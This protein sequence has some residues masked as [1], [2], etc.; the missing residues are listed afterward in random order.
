MKERVKEIPARAVEFWN[1]YTSKQK[2]IIIAVICVVLLLIAL[3]A[4][5]VSRPT[6]TKFNEFSKL[7]DASAMVDALDEQG[8]ANK[9]SKDGLTIY[10]HDDQMTE[11]FYT[12]SDNNLVD[13]GYTWDKAFD[14]SMSTTE[15]EKSQKRVL[16]LQSQL[17]NSMLSYSF[18]DDADVFIDVPESSYSILDEANDTSVTARITVSEKNKE[19]LTTETAQSLAAW[20]AGA[21]GTDVEHVV[22]NDSDGNSVYNGT[23]SDGLGGV[24]TGGVTEYCDKLRNN[25]AQN[26]IKILVKCGYDDVEVGTQ[27][28]KFDMDQAERLTKTYT[29]ADGR[30]YGYPTNVYNYTNEGNSGVAGG[31]P[32]TDTND[33]DET[34]YVLNN[35]SSTN[36]SLEIEKL[37]DL[38]TNET[39]E[40]IKKE[41]PAI[42]FDTS[43]IGIVV[44]RYQVYDEEQLEKDGTLD[45][46]TFDEFMAANN[47]RNTI[48]I[49]DE[50]LELIAAAAG[51]DSANV[52][53][54]A[55]EVPKFIEKTGSSRSVSDY[56]MIILAVLI[57]ALL[58]FVVLRG[59]A[60]MKVSETEPELSVEQLLA[61]T[62]ENQSLEDIEFSDK[63]ETRK[64]IEKFVD[65]NPEA[66]AQ[67]LRNWIT[68]DWD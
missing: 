4:Y 22:I 23:A 2:T 8:I 58:I 54:V 36:S 32:G 11:A 55:Y 61:T 66:V 13:T 45:N 14:N 6:W 30:E 62:K 41:L 53:V 46:M 21:V 29:V 50:E 51:V 38:L 56:L 9:S 39:I 57:I 47:N 20:L 65:E 27:G 25:I 19:L 42:E 15:S 5:L 43:S 1:K 3:A 33:N 12:M 35:G 31:I 40:N 49:S 34:D 67:L 44:T 60:P 64:M 17:K 24:L 59:T 37:T 52:R 26:I 28:V 68:D 48:T 7:E 16:A 10:V 63:S 18:I